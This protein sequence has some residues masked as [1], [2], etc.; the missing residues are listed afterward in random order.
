MYLAIEPKGKKED[1]FNYEREYE[2][3]KN[4]IKRREKIIAIVGVRRIGKTSLMNVIYQEDKNL[5]L[6]IDGRIVRDPIKEIPS[7]IYDVVKNCE[8][9]I[10][11]KIES[12]NVSIFG[13]GLEIKTEEKINEKKMK[14]K[15]LMYS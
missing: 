7:A 9:K 6:W 12:I 4:A 5:K 10:F 2:E 11:E 3:I 1:L 13:I 14:E 8:P 15:R